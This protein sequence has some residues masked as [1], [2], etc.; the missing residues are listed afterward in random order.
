VAQFRAGAPRIGAEVAVAGF[1]YG[2]AIARPALTFG[3]VEDVR[4]LNGEETVR[5]L[6][7]AAQAGDAGGPVLDETGAVIG[8]L[9]P[10]EDGS[11]V[12]PPDVAYALDV[13]AIQA[14]LAQAGVQIGTSS[15]TA[16]L[17]AEQLTR[18]GG[19]MAVLVSCW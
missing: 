8:M 19:N 5:R 1:P 18:S 11:T 7:M 12:L 16:A 10:R 2:G 15:A 4:G 17:G 13:E 14:A 3:T 9:L 6:S